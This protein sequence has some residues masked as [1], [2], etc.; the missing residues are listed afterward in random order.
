M[1]AIHIACILG[2]EDIAL[3][4]LDFVIR[5]TLKTGHRMPLNE[6][7]SRP[8]GEGNTVLHLAAFMGMSRLTK[9]LIETGANVHKK[10]GR[11]YKPVD[12][13]DDDE[14]REVFTTVVP[15]GEPLS[16]KKM[17]ASHAHL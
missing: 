13:V 6:F 17:E 16:M 12:L 11:D 9:K 7:I 1:Y 14:T 15:T 8:C 2:E 3:H 4:L 5:T 10:N